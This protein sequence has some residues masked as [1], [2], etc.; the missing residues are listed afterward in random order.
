MPALVHSYVMVVEATVIIADIL[1]FSSHLSTVYRLWERRRGWIRRLNPNRNNTLKFVS[2]HTTGGQLR[3]YG[4]SK[5]SAVCVF[6][7]VP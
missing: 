4:V 7:Q 1:L 3:T 2:T 5:F 6:S